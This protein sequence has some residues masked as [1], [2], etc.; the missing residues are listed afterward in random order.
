MKNYRWEKVFLKNSRNQQLAGLFHTA[1]L[2]GAPALI[3]CHGFTGSKEGGG[4]AR[5]MAEYFAGAGFDTLLFDFAGNGESE[6]NFE[7]LTLSGQID[8]LKCAV[9]WCKKQGAST[10]ITLGRS[11]G[12]T[13]VICHA[14]KDE[15]VAGVCTWAAP[16]RLVELFTGFMDEDPDDPNKVILAG[17]EGILHMKKTF[18]SDIEKYDVPQLASQIAPRSLLIIHGTKDDVVSP[19]DA[20]LIYTAAGEP[21]ELIYIDGGDHQ[22]ETHHRQVWNICLNWLKTL[23]SNTI[24]RT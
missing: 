20:R 23:N 8:D 1:G 10:I 5:R 15:R 21:K 4:K 24:R 19:E 6:G 11:F 12:G 13:T 22:F 14:A 3:V 18:L 7:D 17:E 16:A 9:D 2:K